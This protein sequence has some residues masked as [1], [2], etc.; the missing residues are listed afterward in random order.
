M[1]SPPYLQKNDTVAII[2]MAGKTSVESIK[3]AIEILKKWGLSV[4]VGES[5]G[6]VDGVF[7]G[8]DSLRKNDFQKQLNDPKI[9]AIFSAR[10]GYGSTRFLDDINWRKFKKNP[11]WVVGFSDITAVVSQINNI[12]IEAIHGPMPKMFANVGAEKS[13][14]YLRKTL[15]GNEITYKAK[16]NANNKLGKATAEI[17]GGNLCILAHTIGSKSEI[18]TD[19]KILFLEDISEYYYNIDRMLLQLKRA[20][21]LKKLAGLIIG[22]FTDCKDGDN[23]Y[24]QTVEQIV[25]HQTQEFDFPI[26][27]GFDIGHEN[28]NW[29]IVCGRKAELVVN[30]MQVSLD[31]R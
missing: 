12:G 21:K 19:G 10:G 15:F 4:V 25:T 3:P 17:V 7:G 29:T 11:K 24:D 14:E 16:I 18:N 31:F 6:A 22:H 20:G 13:L 23:P 5:V 8:S 9:K 2:C 1:I 30:E 26:A 27:F 28:S